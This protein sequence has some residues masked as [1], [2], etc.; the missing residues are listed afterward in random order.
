MACECNANISEEF[1]PQRLDAA[2]DMN[3]LY[4]Q[5]KAIGPRPIK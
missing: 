5:P 3:D 4:V 2:A 1:I